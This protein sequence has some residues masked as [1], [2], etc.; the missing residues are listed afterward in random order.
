MC[1]CIFKQEKKRAVLCFYFEGNS[2]E[3]DAAVELYL[4]NAEAGRWLAA[5]GLIELMRQPIIERDLLYQAGLTSE[6][7]LNQCR[8][9]PF[10]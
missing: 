8:A 4:S 9:E 5:P 10:S 3:L 1:V 2:T 7:A 6:N